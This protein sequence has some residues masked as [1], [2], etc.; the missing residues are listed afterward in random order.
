MRKTSRH[1]QFFSRQIAARKGRNSLS[2][3]LSVLF[4]HMLLICI[5]EKFFV[6]ARSQANKG[7]LPDYGIVNLPDNSA[8]GKK[9]IDPGFLSP[10]RESSPIAF[11][12]RTIPRSRSFCLLFFNYFSDPV[13]IFIAKKFPNKTFPRC[14]ARLTAPSG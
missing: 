10:E 7:M 1:L 5:R 8:A 11:S 12:A 6:T 9:M 14:P 2:L 3:L 4:A 13:F